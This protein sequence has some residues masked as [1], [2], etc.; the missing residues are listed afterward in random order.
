[1]KLPNLDAAHISETKMTDYLLSPTHRVGKGKARFF[2]TFGF[3]IQ[4]WKH[5]AQALLRHAAEHDVTYTEDTPFG[6]RYIIEGKIHTP[7]GRMPWI[8]A[9]WFIDSGQEMP[10]FVTAYPLKKKED[11]HD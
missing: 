9:V 6:K 11:N 2:S 8:R 4:E 7:V 10:R 1:M 3:S 5:L